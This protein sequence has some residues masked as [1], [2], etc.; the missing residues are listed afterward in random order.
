ML[1]YSCAYTFD[2]SEFFFAIFRTVKEKGCFGKKFCTVRFLMRLK[3]DYINFKLLIFFLFLTHESINSVFSSWIL[4]SIASALFLDVLLNQIHIASISSWFLGTQG[5]TTCSIYGFL[6]LS[7]TPQ[8]SI[9]TTAFNSF[10]FSSVYVR[11]V[12]IS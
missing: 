11:T 2:V 1:S 12:K 8:D 5:S 4:F 7:R 6:I 9:D 3:N 10:I